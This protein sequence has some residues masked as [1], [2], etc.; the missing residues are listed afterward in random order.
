MPG[1]SGAKQQVCARSTSRAQHHEEGGCVQS[2]HSGLVAARRDIKQT[3]P[4]SLGA[5]RWR[6]TDRPS[7]CPSRPLV[8]GGGTYRDLGATHG[9]SASACIV[10]EPNRTSALGVLPPWNSGPPLRGV[11]CATWAAPLDQNPPSR[12]QQKVAGKSFSPD[13]TSRQIPD[14]NVISIFKGTGSSFWSRHSL[15]LYSII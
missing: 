9:H 14:K 12:S 2:E 5:S 8:D 13:V 4:A 7:T 15:T 10:V 6:D 1:R 11:L 3:P